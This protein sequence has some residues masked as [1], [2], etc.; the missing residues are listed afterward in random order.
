MLCA[1]KAHSLYNCINLVLNC[2]CFAFFVQFVDLFF[3][4]ST[5]QAKYLI[6]STVKKLIVSS[7]TLRR[8]WIWSHV[9]GNA[10]R[11]MHR[12]QKSPML[13]LYLYDVD[14]F[15]TD[16]NSQTCCFST[17]GSRESWYTRLWTGSE[18]TFYPVPFVSRVSIGQPISSV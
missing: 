18:C 3:L 2:S 6:S 8:L 1:A 12:P 10:C 5:N 14:V 13:V 7:P 9:P 11:P 17:V 4:Y 16:S 15:V